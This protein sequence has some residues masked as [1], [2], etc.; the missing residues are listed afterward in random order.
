MPRMPYMYRARGAQAKTAEKTRLFPSTIT[1]YSTY[2]IQFSGFPPSRSRPRSE[3]MLLQYSN[4]FLKHQRNRR[5]CN[6]TTVVPHVGPGR[7]G[8]REFVVMMMIIDCHATTTPLRVPEFNRAAN[9]KMSSVNDR[10][11]R[12]LHASEP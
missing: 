6:C 3:H 7:R 1:Y 11:S 8:S 9:C 2:P 10:D 5:Y 12:G 4:R